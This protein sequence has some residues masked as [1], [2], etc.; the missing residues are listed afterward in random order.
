MALNQSEIM[1]QL[2]AFHVSSPLCLSD[3]RLSDPQPTEAIDFE[4]K[5]IFQIDPILS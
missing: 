4:P 3:H 1:E 2:F 5:A